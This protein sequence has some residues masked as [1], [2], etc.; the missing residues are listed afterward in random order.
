MAADDHDVVIV[1]SGASG[2][3]AAWNLTRK[4]AKV[5][6]LEAGERFER[7]DFW[8]HVKP[9]EER[10][11]RRR[12]ERSPG[13]ETLPLRESPYETL[14]GQHF[15]LRRVWGVG[16]KTNIWGRVSLRYG[17]LNFKEPAVDGWGIPWPVSYSE[18]APYY[19]NVEKLIGVC[20]GA[21]DSKFLPGSRHHLPPPNLRCGEVLLRQGAEKAG[22][23]VVNGRRAV[24]TAEHRGRA[25]C[26]YCGACGKG[27]DIGAF[28]NSRD[29][30]LEDAFA[31]G[32]LELRENA[33][34][35]HVL[36]DEDGAASGVR[37]FDRLSGAERTVAAKRVIVAASAVDSTRIL[38]NS[39][40]SAHPNGIGNGSDVIGRYLCEQFRFHVYAFAPQL[41]GRPATNDDGISG[42]HIYIP[43]FESPEEKRDY[44]RGFG[45]QLWGIGCGSNAQFAK[46]MSGFGLDFKRDVRKSYPALVQ[47]HPYGEVLPYR[48][49]RIAVDGTP[50]DRFGVPTIRIEYKLGENERKMLPRMY[51]V[52]EEILNSMRAEPLPYRRGDLDELGAAIH[53]HGTCRMGEDPKR[54]ALNAYMQ[55]HEVPNV[56]VVDGSAF[57]TPTEKNPTLSILAFAWRAT[58]YMAEQMRLG[59]I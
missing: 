4:G 30:L 29:Y 2:G 11:R 42:G 25:K 48:H 50:P 13:F 31:T 21:D 52:V 45:I 7:A 8:S 40:S 32:K 36:T 20:G 53:E 27:C 19:D 43:R 16:G 44:M 56:F 23:T 3:M 15:L 18:I 58:D 14:A 33:I 12:G 37:Y 9:W 51:D 24:L 49:N 1:G 59:N 22:Y 39:K 34:V 57:P 35:S 47:M 54:S 46:R 26:H 6:M 38:L 55:M 41:Y 17:D 10:E 28:F 5:L